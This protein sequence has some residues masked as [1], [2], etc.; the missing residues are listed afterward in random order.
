MVHTDEATIKKEFVNYFKSILAERKDCSPIDPAVVKNGE[1]LEDHQCRALIREAT[2][3]D[4]WKALSKIGSDKSPGPDGFSA[5]FFCKN[6]S[7][8]GKELC[9]GIRHCLKFNALLKCSGLDVNSD[10]SQLFLAS[11]SEAKRRWVESLVNCSGSALPAIVF[12]WARI[13]ILPSKVLQGNSICANFLWNGYLWQG[14]EFLG[15]FESAD[16]MAFAYPLV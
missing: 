4:I 16:L 13:C 5:S 1:L 3:L 14:D 11:M 6:W 15:S 8:V 7:L 10:K 9:S 2:D 12:Y